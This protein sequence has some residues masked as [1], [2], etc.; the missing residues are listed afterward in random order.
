[1]TIIVCTHRTIRT[2]RDLLFSPRFRLATWLRINFNVG[3]LNKT[4][5]K[6]VPMLLRFS[7]NYQGI[8]ML[9]FT[10]E[11]FLPLTNAT[12]HELFLHGTAVRLHAN[13]Q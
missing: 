13:T 10:T 7:R 12:V 6:Y 1:M 5:A 11:T 8:E 2:T 3:L 4:Q 9:I